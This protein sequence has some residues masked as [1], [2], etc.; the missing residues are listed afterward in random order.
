MFAGSKYLW[1]VVMKGKGVVQRNMNG[2]KHPRCAFSVDGL[3]FLLQPFVLSRPGRHIR[4]ST[5][6]DMFGRAVRE[7][8]VC[9]APFVGQRVR[10]GVHVEVALLV[11]LIALVNTE[12]WRMDARHP[13]P[14][15]VR[16]ENLLA[17]RLLINV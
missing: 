12:F 7:S 10:W 13:E 17:S 6:D 5:H 16:H 14:M 11:H 4:V 9:I 8:V 3:E 15:F 2:D 1:V